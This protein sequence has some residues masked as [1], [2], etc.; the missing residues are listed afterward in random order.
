M[1]HTPRTVEEVYEDYLGRRAGLIKALTA[2]ARWRAARRSD[3][4]TQRRSE[5]R[6]FLSVD[7]ALWLTPFSRCA[8]QTSTGSTSS[9]IPRRRAVTAV[10]GP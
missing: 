3:A 7:S 1:E 10:P 9:V 4:V 8:R 5:K 6:S 2:G